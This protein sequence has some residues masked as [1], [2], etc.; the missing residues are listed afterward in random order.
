MR[1]E[2][3]LGR[4]PS[5]AELTAELHLTEEEVS[6]GQLAAPGY[7]ARSLDIPAGADDAAL[8]QDGAATGRASG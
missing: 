3:G 5:R 6:E 1:R 8:G 2:P 7:A 4:R